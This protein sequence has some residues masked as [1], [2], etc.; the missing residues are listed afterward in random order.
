MKWI[1]TCEHYA[2]H[3][4][5]GYSHLFSQA[6]EVL[7]SHRGYDIGAAQVFHSVEDQFDLSFVY[8]HTRLLVEPN[9]S[10][11]HR[12]LFSA[13]SLQLSREERLGLIAKYYQP[14]R[15]QVEQAVRDNLHETVIHISLHTFTPVL[16]NEQRKAEVGLLFDPKREHE[17]SLAELWKQCLKSE[18]PA[19][20]VRFNYP[21]RGSADGFTTYL[22]KCF[23]S[24]YVG[25]EL[26]LRNDVASTLKSVVR[27]SID[28]LRKTLG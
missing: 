26:E 23:P 2:N 27:N 28:H 4:P 14:Y 21:Y 25:F 12:H 16:G 7:Q 19:L 10:L 9:R 24:H 22:R 1:L 5:P 20:K 11:H 8:P 6:A 13:F 17:K 3:V 18:A 15:K